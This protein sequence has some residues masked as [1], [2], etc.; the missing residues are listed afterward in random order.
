MNKSI[1]GKIIFRVG[2][3]VVICMIL[4]CVIST[5]MFAYFFVSSENKRLSLSSEYTTSLITDYVS[6]YLTLAQDISMDPETIRLVDAGAQTDNEYYPSVYAFLNAITMNDS[7]NIL[8]AYVGSIKSSF[9]FDGGDWESDEDFDLSTRDYWFSTKEQLDRGYIVTEPYEDLD[10]HQIVTTVSTPVYNESGELV[11]IAAIDIT[12]TTLCDVVLRAESGFREGS[13]FLMSNEGLIL[14]HDNPDHLLESYNDIEMSD[15]IKKAIENGNELLVTYRADGIRRVGKVGVEPVSGFKVVSSVP[16]SA[17]LRTITFILLVLILLYVLAIVIVIKIISIVAKGISAPV[18]HLTELTRK[19]ADG[20]L[21]VDVDVHQED[22][23]GHLADALESLVGRL[24]EYILYIDETSS[25]LNKMGEGDLH[26]EFVSAYDGEFAA[27]KTSMTE[28]SHMLSTTLD[29]MDHIS[30][31]VA[32][33]AIRV[34]NGAKELADGATDQSASVEELTSSLTTVT[35][36]TKLLSESVQEGKRVADEVKGNATDGMEKMNQVVSSMDDITQTSAKIAEITKTIEDIASQTN[37]LSLNAS[38]EAAR[39]GQSG[40]GF[41]VVADE[42]RKLAGQSAEA[43]NHT[44]ELIDHTIENVNRG[45]AVVSES[46]AALTLISDGISHIQEIMTHNAEVAMRQSDAVNEIEKGI[47]QIS[48][49][50]EGNAMH[51][52]ESAA[53]SQVLSEL[54]EKQRDLLSVFRKSL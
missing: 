32:E 39:A 42:I 5:A 20:D 15:N 27:I 26:P 21:N 43:A 30:G 35:T 4:T 45:N 37:L 41:A 18:V 28:M 3:I 22:E 29:N 34:S 50:V 52:Q 17:Y 49:V 54:A 16:R 25:L 7:E 48:Q 9:A 8:S 2:R 19:M 24:K 31:E 46:S 36:Q 1:R 40:K 11:G 13:Q 12:I 44:K 53:S 33:N 38:I 10:T 51:A 47:E 23:V 6:K 14:A